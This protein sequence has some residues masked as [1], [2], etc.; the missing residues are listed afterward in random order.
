MATSNVTPGAAET[1]EKTASPV[2]RTVLDLGSFAKVQLSKEF[3]APPKPGSVEEALA[4]VGNDS[5]KLLDLIY[6]GL[7]KQ[8]RDAQYAD[9][10]GFFVVED[11]EVT[12]TPY[13]GTFADGKKLKSINAM[14]INMAKANVDWE[15]LDAAGKKA[16]KQEV[17]DLIKESPKM[18]ARL[19]S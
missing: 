4:H 16:A 2:T 19:Q 8:A 7:E 15:S 17:I 14:V 11:D 9:I 12:E 5:Q 10:N 1:T 6:A 3:V 13:T 18:L